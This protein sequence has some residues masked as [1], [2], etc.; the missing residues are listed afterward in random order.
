M[1]A[2]VSVPLFSLGLGVVLLFASMAFSG[3][4]TAYW[5]GV[6]CPAGTQYGFPLPFQYDMHTSSATPP[7]THSTLVCPTRDNV[8]PTKTNL[9]NVLDD[10][11]FWFAISLPVVFGFSHLVATRRSEEEASAKLSPELGAV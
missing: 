9:S 11:L 3:S 6:A 4:N 8:M 10:Y 2:Y 7:L 1:K 5:N